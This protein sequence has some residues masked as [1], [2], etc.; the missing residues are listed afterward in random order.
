MR[1]TGAGVAE[2]ETQERNLEVYQRELETIQ[3]K[4]WTILLIS[5]DRSLYKNLRLVAN[6]QGH[7]VVKTDKL[8][9]MLPVFQAIKPTAVLLDLD[10]P[11]HEAWQAAELLLQQQTCPPVVLLTAQTGQFDLRTAIRAGSLVDKNGDPARILQAVRESLDLPWRNQAERN[12]IQRVLLRWLKPSNW[13][14]DIAPA[15]R[16]WGI[17]E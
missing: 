8:Q 14:G 15:Y 10:F 12:A 17:N 2:R 13:A 7:M 16:F 4:R 6:I 3:P 5:A 9:G 1:T 11:E